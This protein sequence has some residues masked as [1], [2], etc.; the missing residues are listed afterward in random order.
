MKADLETCGISL[1]QPP[2]YHREQAQ[3]RGDRVRNGERET[4][5]QAVPET[6]ISLHVSIHESIHFLFP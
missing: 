3:P 5:D 1:W 6:C 4:L 2:C